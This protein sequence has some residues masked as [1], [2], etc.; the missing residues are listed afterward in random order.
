ML[1]QVSVNELDLQIPI[2]WFD[3]ERIIKTRVLVSL[4]LEYQSNTIND[5]LS[6]TIDYAEMHQLLKDCVREYKL[7]E[8]YGEVVLKAAL[9][10]FTNIQLTFGVIE[11][12]KKQILEGNSK[13]TS[14]VVKIS[15]KY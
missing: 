5:D 8:T 9:D 11:I 4:H 13:S 7:L 15:R 3:E 1:I 2:G 10:R 12:T 14:Q 6:N